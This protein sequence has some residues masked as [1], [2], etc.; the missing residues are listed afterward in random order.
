MISSVL[1]PGK[2]FDLRLFSHTP[3]RSIFLPFYRHQGTECSFRGPYLHYCGNDTFDSE[4]SRM[5]VSFRLIPKLYFQHYPWSPTPLHGAAHGWVTQ[6]V[7]EDSYSKSIISISPWN[8]KMSLKSSSVGAKVGIK[9]GIMGRKLR[10]LG[11]TLA[12]RKHFGRFNS[13]GNQQQSRS[14]H[15]SGELA[16]QSSTGSTPDKLHLS[17]QPFLGSESGLCRGRYLTFYSKREARMST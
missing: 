14:R 4:L 16:P 5:L 7:Q 15:S 13:V 3:C 9:S 6:L 17:G 10:A 12:A 2:L 1:S 8:P 11:K